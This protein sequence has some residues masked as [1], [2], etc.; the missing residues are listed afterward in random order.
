MK[1]LYLTTALILCSLLT[2]CGVDQADFDQANSEIASLKRDLDECQNGA[3]KLIAQIDQ[4]YQKKDYP[5]TK[6]KIKQLNARH[7]ESPKNAEYR[8]LLKEIDSLEAIEKERKA[9]EEKE[10][11]RKANFNNTGM[12]KLDYYVD[13]FGDPTKDGYITNKNMIN[14]SFSNTATQDSRLN[15]RFLISD[16][17]RISILL[18][19]YARNNPVKSYSYDSYTVLVKDAEGNRSK[20][21]AANTSDRLV[22]IKADSKKLHQIL[23]AGGKTVFRITEDDSPTTIYEFEI[24]N[25]EYYDNAYRKLIEG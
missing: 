23:K 22:L 7:P 21:R 12:W 17:S 11:K 2:A 10:A 14:G 4:A 16:S 6:E 5:T 1:T 20:F 25:A 15:V 19:E 3:D 8:E 24:R 9:A 18:Y 13:D